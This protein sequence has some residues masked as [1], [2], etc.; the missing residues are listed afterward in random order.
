MISKKE[1]NKFTTEMWKRL[2]AGEKIYGDKYKSAD[3]AKEML[4]ECSD[5]SNYALL[6]YYQ[7][8]Y[9]KTVK[10]IKGGKYGK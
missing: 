10:Q 1:F 2:K 4:E 7:A 3:I 8:K 5:I 9:S 6:L